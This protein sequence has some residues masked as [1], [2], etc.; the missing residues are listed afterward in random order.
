MRNRR[1]RREPVAIRREAVEHRAEPATA[2]RRRL[3]TPSSRKSKTR[4]DIA[5]P[6]GESDGQDC[7]LPARQ[8]TR[9][10]AELKWA[11]PAPL[12]SAKC[13]QGCRLETVVGDIEN[14]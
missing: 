8:A 2:T 5:S 9:Y 7:R 1:R 4:S 14:G 6:G 11:P 12:N 10:L 3:S 13:C